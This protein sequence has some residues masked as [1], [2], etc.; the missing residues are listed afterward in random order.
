[1]GTARRNLFSASAHAS[2]C[3]TRRLEQAQEIAVNLPVSSDNAICGQSY[4]TALEIA[5]ESSGLPHQGNSGG[6]V[7]GRKPALPISIEA[8]GS[9]PGEIERGR[10]E[11]P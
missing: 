2:L 10:S 9:H 8:A 5:D 11:P 7:P 3:P 6:H 1:M 4:V